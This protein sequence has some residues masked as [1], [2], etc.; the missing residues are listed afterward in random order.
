MMKN[1]G[2]MWK[3]GEEEEMEEERMKG[4]IIKREDRKG[5]D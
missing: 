1:R 2:N 4:Q 3:E 5:E